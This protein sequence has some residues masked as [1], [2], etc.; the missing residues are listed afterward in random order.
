MQD[1]LNDE[2]LR[3]ANVVV[4]PSDPSVPASLI[5]NHPINVDGLARVGPTHAPEVGEHT[6]EVLGE[7]GFSAAEIEALRTSGAT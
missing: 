6:A 7:L 3:A 1:L 2:Q 4:Q 5:V